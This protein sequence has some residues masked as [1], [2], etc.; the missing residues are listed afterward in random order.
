MNFD[1]ALN[2]LSANF[3]RVEFHE[4]PMAAIG[5]PSSFSEV[6]AAKCAVV[7]DSASLLSY[8]FVFL[9]IDE[10]RVPHYFTVI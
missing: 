5:S 10:F 1:S 3:A 7:A 6:S 9:A 2:D 4:G 8:S